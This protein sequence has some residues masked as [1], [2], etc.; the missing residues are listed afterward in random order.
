MFVVVYCLGGIVG[1]S[2]GGFAMDYWSPNGLLVFLSA[3]PLPLAA[4][5]LRRG[6]STAS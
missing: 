1:P 6:R 4:G 2:L 5:L 3:A